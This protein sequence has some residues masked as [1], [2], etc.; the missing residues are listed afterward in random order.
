V[1][2][3][4]VNALKSA[5]LVLAFVLELVVL[6]AVGYWGFT[7][8]PRLGVKLVAG[9]GAPLLLIILWAVFGSPR[10][11][12]HLSQN[13]HLAFAIVWFGV[14]F[15]ALGL[16]GRVSW[17]TVLAVVYVVHAVLARVWNQE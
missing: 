3:N 13:A 6:A 11:P 7:L 9:I 14:G 2:E 8:S 16:A 4:P 5:N 15:V 1:Q 12:V 17:A 10:A